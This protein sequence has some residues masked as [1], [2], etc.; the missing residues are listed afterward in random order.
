V[1]HVYYRISGWFGWLTDQRSPRF[2]AVSSFVLIIL[3][4]VLLYLWGEG[5]AII[6]FIAFSILWM[7]LGGWIAI[8]PTATAMFFGVRHYARNYAI[9]FSAYGVGAI[10]G[11]ALSGAI[12]DATGSYL[13]VFLPVI[14]LAILGMV[15]SLV[16]L[17]PIKSTVTTYV[18]HS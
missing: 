1:D 6:Y 10:L 8:A 4:S 13:P 9:I 7:N 16:G 18:K 14:G 17:N 11:T 15:I 3:A 12:K 5:S 2:A